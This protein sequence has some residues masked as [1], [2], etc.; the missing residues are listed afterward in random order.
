V[1]VNAQAAVEDVGGDE[2]EVE[3]D[4]DEVDPPVATVGLPSREHAAMVAP[5]RATAVRTAASRRTPRG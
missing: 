5:P 3:E 4:D 1:A 2:D